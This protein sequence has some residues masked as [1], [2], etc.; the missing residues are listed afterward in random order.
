VAQKVN[1]ERLEALQ[2]HVL[3]VKGGGLQ[4][5]LV[6]VVVLEP[7]GVVPVSAICGTT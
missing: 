4:D 3:N 2:V 5:N 6:L 7:I 1:P